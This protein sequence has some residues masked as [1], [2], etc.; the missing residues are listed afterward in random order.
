MLKADCEVFVIP[1]R[2]RSIMRDRI[3]AGY[4]TCL[5][6]QMFAGNISPILVWQFSLCCFSCSNS[7]SQ[8]L[9]ASAI[10]ASAWDARLSASCFSRSAFKLR[11]AAG[12]VAVINFR[13]GCI[14]TRTPAIMKA[15]MPKTCKSVKFHQISPRRPDNALPM[16][17]R[18]PNEPL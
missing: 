17:S 1:R 18:Q 2:T 8:C 15:I 16:N 12:T 3:S 7:V 13:T 4:L 6:W 10:L 9:V 5:L 11:S 14:K